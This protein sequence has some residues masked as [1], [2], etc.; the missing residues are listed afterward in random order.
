MRVSELFCYT[1]YAPQCHRDADYLSLDPS[2]SVHQY[3]F[4]P[5]AESGSYTTWKPMDENAARDTTYESPI[6]SSCSDKTETKVKNGSGSSDDDNSK[7]PKFDDELATSLNDRRKGK[8][9]S[10]HPR[11][12]KDKEGPN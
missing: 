6:S 1:A 4:V 11:Q 3:M 5:L 10:K 12:A 2:T 7:R 8:S 9:N